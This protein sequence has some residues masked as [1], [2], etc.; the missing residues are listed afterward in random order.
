MVY[1]LTCFL[2]F[3]LLNTVKYKI[4][5][6]NTIL[7]ITIHAITPLLRWFDESA[8]SIDLH[9]CDIS[10]IFVTLKDPIFSLEYVKDVN[11]LSNLLHPWNAF[12]LTIGSSIP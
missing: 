4:I 6:I 8:E 11:I 7:K 3:I 1:F 12:W 10:D 9:T 2:F 5:Q